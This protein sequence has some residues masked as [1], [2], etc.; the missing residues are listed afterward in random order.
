MK[1]KWLVSNTSA[2]LQYLYVLCAFKN[3]PGT[4]NQVFTCHN[5]MRFK[6]THRLKWKQ[7]CLFSNFNIILKV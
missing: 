4:E 5:P 3:E 6:W 7:L 1:G 2:F